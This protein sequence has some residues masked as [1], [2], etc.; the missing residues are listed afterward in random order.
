VLTDQFWLLAAEETWDAS[1]RARADS[2]IDR[3]NPTYFRDW[4]P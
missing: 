3:A 4:K 1:V 2:I